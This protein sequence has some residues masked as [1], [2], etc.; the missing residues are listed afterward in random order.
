MGK[1][2]LFSDECSPRSDFGQSRHEVPEERLSTIA[3][4][5][6]E[7]AADEAVRSELPDI[8]NSDESLLSIMERGD[9]PAL[10]GAIV[11]LYISLHALGSKYSAAERK[12]LDIRSGYSCYPGGLLPLI[13]AGP[14]IRRESI[15]VDL[16]AG[17]GLQ[18]LFLQRLYPHRK[19]LQVELSGE[20]IRIGRVFQQALGIPDNRI[21]WINDDI[22]NV[23]IDSADFIYIYRPARPQGKGSEIYRAIARKLTE[24]HRPRVVFSVADCLG[25][26]LD[27][28]SV[29]YTDG[30]LTCFRKD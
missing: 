25:E 11:D 14:H 5:M 16:G 27:G 21:T 26:F 23:S 18:G 28:F 3:L 17:N 20:M 10:E 4:A 22:L 1:G 12:V 30:H 9:A 13:M 24:G 8:G 7:L 29:F 15:V 2:N 6:L 19:T